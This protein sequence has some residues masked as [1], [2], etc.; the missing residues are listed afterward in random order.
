[1]AT[2]KR[3]F[4]LWSYY[5]Y[6]RK[7]CTFKINV[8]KVCDN[9][10]FIML[11]E[12]ENTELNIVHSYNQYKMWSKKIGDTF[13]GKGVCLWVGDLQATLFSLYYTSVF[14]AFLKWV[15]VNFKLSFLDIRKRDNQ[16]N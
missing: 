2:S 16:R 9:A 15:Y 13:Q 4:L 10:H 11:S 8:Y 7:Q 14:L 1:M 5:F 3:E 12:D 6:N